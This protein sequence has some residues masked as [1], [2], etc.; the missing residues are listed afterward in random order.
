MAGF[1]IRLRT[2]GSS[3]VRLSSLSLGLAL[4]AGAAL[5]VIG[6]GLSR[7]QSTEATV[8]VLP[9]MAPRAMAGQGPIISG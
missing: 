8:R 1:H 9:R 2:S 6:G 3:V 7:A 4:L 5:L